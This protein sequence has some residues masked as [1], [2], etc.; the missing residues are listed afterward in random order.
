MEWSDQAYF[1]AVTSLANRH[2]NL[3]KLTYAGNLDNLAD[4]SDNLN[5][6]F[7]EGDIVDRKL[8]DDLALQEYSRT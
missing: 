8:V 7:V 6:S 4:V 1:V 3:D 2:I 5:Y